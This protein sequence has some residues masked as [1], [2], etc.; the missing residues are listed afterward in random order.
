M[1]RK[2]TYRIRFRGDICCIDMSLVANIVKGLCLAED[3]DFIMGGTTLTVRTTEEMYKNCA[4]TIS[5][6]WPGQFIFEV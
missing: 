2:K 6:M 4:K 3:K 1:E 5:S